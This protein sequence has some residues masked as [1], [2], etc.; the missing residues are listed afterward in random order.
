MLAKT[1]SVLLLLIVAAVVVRAKSHQNS[2]TITIET[3]EPGVV[4]LAEMV[5]FADTVALV[6]IVSGDTESYDV[7]VYKAAVVESFKG[8]TAGETV[9]FGP[10]VG[11]RL[12]WEYIVFL[13]KGD[14]P[15]APRQK[16][17]GSYGTV[18]YSRIFNQGY[19]AMEAGYECVFNDSH[20]GESCD[21]SVRVCTDYVVL[22]KSIEAFPPLS[23]QT[24]FGCRWV[25]KSD[26][27][28][29]LRT[30]DKSKKK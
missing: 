22:P 27:L 14:K 9:Y 17:G 3:K 30:L 18:D 8:A 12:G 21:Y 10:F 26:F 20:G 4:V 24:P 23:A 19:S 25:R 11:Q 1:A 5:E 16:S 15:L 2:K 28:A 7:A 13:R 6:K 29:I